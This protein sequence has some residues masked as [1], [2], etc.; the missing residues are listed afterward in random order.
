MKKIVL[1]ILMSFFVPNAAVSIEWPDDVYIVG[2]EAAKIIEKGKIIEI[3]GDDDNFGVFEKY[4]V[5]VIYEGVLHRC[6]MQFSASVIKGK[7]SR[8]RC[9]EFLDVEWED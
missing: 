9:E 6:R 2:K 5:R 3:T 4:T 8:V 7:I 1:L